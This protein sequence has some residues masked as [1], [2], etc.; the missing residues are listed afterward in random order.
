MRESKFARRAAAAAGAGAVVPDFLVWRRCTS[1]S[2]RCI[3]TRTHSFEMLASSS[4]F[5][6]ISRNPCS[7]S[8]SSFLSRCASTCSVACPRPK[9]DSPE[10][11]HGRQR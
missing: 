2:S 10:R 6:F 5:S 1:P 11:Q 8:F 7:T 4:R 3:V 9:P